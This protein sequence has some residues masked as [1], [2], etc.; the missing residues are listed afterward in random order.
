MAELIERTGSVEPKQAAH[1]VPVPEQLRDQL[2]EHVRQMAEEEDE[3]SAFMGIKLIATPSPPSRVCYPNTVYFT[4][5]S[6]MTHGRTDYAQ[7]TPS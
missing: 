1:V 3:V 5:V 7:D 4:A 6:S 2:A